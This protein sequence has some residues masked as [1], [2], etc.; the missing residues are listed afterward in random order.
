MNKNGKARVATAWLGGCSGCHMS[1]LDLDERLIDLADRV[2]LVYSPIVDIKEYPENVD[3]ALVE[4]AICNEEHLEQI[5]L[6]RARTRILVSF[7]DCAVA[8][9][10]TAMRNMCCSKESVLQRAYIENATLQPQ[11]PVAPG[12]VP[13]L[14]ARVV[15]VH[16]VVPVDV[17]LPGCPPSGD[18]IHFVLSELLAGRTPDLNDRLVYG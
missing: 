5:R 15:P 2:A 12:I 13:P 7:G 17:Y 10:V 6:I 9:N 4:G 1:F 8:G 11:L 16:E 18:L 3:V 14:L